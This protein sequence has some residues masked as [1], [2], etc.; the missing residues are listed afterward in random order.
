MTEEDLASETSYNFLNEA[1]TTDNIQE[2]N[3]AN[4]A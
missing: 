1:N 3:C 4:D 2:N